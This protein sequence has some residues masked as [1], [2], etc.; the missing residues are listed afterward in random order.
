MNS[1]D[2]QQAA[3][4]R[5]A[6]A[7]L[8]PLFSYL[9]FAYLASLSRELYP[10][11]YAGAVGIVTGVTI[12]CLRGQRV[13]QP[14]R[15]V[16]PAVAVGIVGCG[17]WIGLFHLHLEKY[18]IEFL[19][20]ALQPSGR[21]AYDPQREI[22]D[23]LGRWSFIAVRFAGLVLLVPVVEEIFWRGF[24]A[25]WLLG[26]D[27][28]QQP[29]GRFTTSSF[30]IVTLLFTAAHAEL[31]SAAVY[32]VLLNVLIMWRRD[33]WKCVVAHA[34][35]NLALGMYILVTETWVLW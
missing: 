15:D 14:H 21:M 11:L 13:L 7:Y 32:C 28:Q 9:V 25:R 34:V 31:L 26:P 4:N 16:A 24:L 29:L 27:W 1:T 3:T 30:L 35:S 20:A 23:P 2:G 6:I 12:V 8:G 19:P 22:A 5:A 17:L 33:L 18:L 10:W